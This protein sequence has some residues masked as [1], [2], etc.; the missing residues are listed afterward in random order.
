MR[1]RRNFLAIFLVVCMCLGMMPCGVY[2]QEAGEPQNDDPGW[3]RY[4]GYASPDFY[5]PSGRAGDRKIQHD[6]RFNGCIVQKGI[7][8]SEWNGTVN[9]EKV[10]AAGYE[11]AIIRVAGCWAREEGGLFMDSRAVQNIEGALAAGMSI[12]VYFFSQAITEKEAQKEAQ[13]ILDAIRPYKKKIKLPVVF[14]FEF[15]SDADGEGGRLY[16]AGLSKAKATK[17]C[18]KFCST[19]EASGYTPMLYTNPNM[20]Y[21][22]L[23]PSE[24]TSTIWLAQWASMASY[25]GDYEFW[26]YSATGKVP[27]IKGFTDLDFRYVKKGPLSIAA[28]SIGSIR[29]EWRQ[30]FGASG[31]HIYRKKGEG[32]YQLAGSVSGAK[33]VTYSDRHLTEGTSYTYRV[34]PYIDAETGRQNGFYTKTAT[35]ITKLKKTVLRGQAKGSHAVKLSWEK[36]SKASGYELQRYDPSKKKYR[37]LKTVRGRGETSFKDKGLNAGKTYRYRIRAYKNIGGTK[38]YS[39]WSDKKAVKTKK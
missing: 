34:R 39:S 27:G 16:H 15:Y 6:S 38:V 4:F 22:Y 18:N 32:A 14:D 9:W 30:A 29:V 36:S 33:T 19:V 17:I 23:K 1:K 2:A 20:L 25:P 11:F 35:G 8:V 13:F 24:I 26:Q 5:G 31:Y 7:D 3:G 10:K 21:N 28:T 12:G 37:A